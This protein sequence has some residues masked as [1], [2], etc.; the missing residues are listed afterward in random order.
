MWEISGNRG[1]FKTYGHCNVVR[2]EK[3][4]VILHA[5]SETVYSMS[6]LC[7]EFYTLCGCFYTAFAF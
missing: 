3:A 1:N 2:H 6:I 4:V 5:H 7:D